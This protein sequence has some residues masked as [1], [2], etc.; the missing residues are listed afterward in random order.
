MCCAV[1]CKT[2]PEYNTRVGR[3]FGNISRSGPYE[4]LYVETAVQKDFS[5]KSMSAQ[6]NAFEKW[7]KK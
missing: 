4:S 7:P 1:I 5:Q 3:Y 2:V 6:E